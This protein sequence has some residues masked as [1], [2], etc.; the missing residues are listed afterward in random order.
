MS[1]TADGDGRD[2]GE[3]PLDIVVFFFQKEN[4]TKAIVDEKISLAHILRWTK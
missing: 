2:G 3:K 1:A 4:K